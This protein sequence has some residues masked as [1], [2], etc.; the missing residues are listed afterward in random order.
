MAKKVTIQQLATELN[1]ST[2][3]VSR[4]LNDHPLIN[5]ETKRKVAELANQLGYMARK[6]APRTVENR[7]RK[8]IVWVTPLAN[9]EFED[10]IIL[11]ILGGM[12]SRT[13]ELGRHFLHIP[14]DASHELETYRDLI[15][16]DEIG[17]FIVA[18]R[19]AEGDRRIEFLLES[20]VPFIAYG[21]ASTSNE[22]PWVHVDFAGAYREGTSHLLGLGHRRIAML[23]AMPGFQTSTERESGYR[24][25]MAEHDVPVSANWVVAGPKNE[26][27]GYRCM[28]QLLEITP[29]PTAVICSSVITAKGALFAIDER[30]LVI[31]QDISLVAFDD[32]I[33]GTFYSTPL[34]T[35][36]S[37]VRPLGRKIVDLLERAIA[38][39]DPAGLQ[40]VQHVELVVRASTGPVPIDDERPTARS[41]FPLS[42][43]PPESSSA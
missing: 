15:A 2:A 27:F 42:S 31:G 37:P 16:S 14:T 20:K 8:P 29:A 33:A 12:V 43:R 13:M 17:G 21:A 11:E 1:L 7:A 22:Y 34:T 38:G 18:N 41:E 23:N 39:E 28:Q 36:F 19:L 32:N 35:M 26:E 5:T 4:A 6:S 9:F 10:P 24:R 40:L 30:G 25:A 3:T